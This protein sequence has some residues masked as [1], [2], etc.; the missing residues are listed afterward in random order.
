M[1]FLRHGEIY[2][3][4]RARPLRTAPPTHRLDEFPAGYS[5]AGCS[6]AEP[7]SASPA[8][9][10]SEVQSYRRSSV[11]HRTAYSVLT[12]CLTPGGRRTQRLLYGVI[13]IGVGSALLYMFLADLRQANHSK[14]WPHVEGVILSSKTEDEYI[15]PGLWTLELEYE[16]IVDE[17]KHRGRFKESWVSGGYVIRDWMAESYPEGKQVAVYYNPLIPEQSVLVPGLTWQHFWGGPFFLMGGA[18]L[19]LCACP[20]G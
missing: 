1:S 17:V 3:P 13:C 20:L 9:A 7:A 18:L 11:F 16:Y 10:H 4:M 6:P 15:D 2:P 14:D 19:M 8:D 12:G 5:W